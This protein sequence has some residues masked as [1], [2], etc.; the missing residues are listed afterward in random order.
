MLNADVERE[1]AEILRRADKAQARRTYREVGIR[2]AISLVWFLVG[3]WTST[4]LDRPDYDI[5]RVGIDAPG[6][7]KDPV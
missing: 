7:G 3:L 5:D 4:L 2:L 1:V 6:V